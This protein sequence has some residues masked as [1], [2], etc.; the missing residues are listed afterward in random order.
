MERIEYFV[1]VSGAVL[2][3]SVAAYLL[4]RS[5]R[6]LEIAD[7]IR[8]VILPDG[9]GGPP[10]TGAS[11]MTIMVGFGVGMVTLFASL[12]LCVLGL[13]SVLPAWTVV[14]LPGPLRWA[15]LGLIWC[16]YGWGVAVVA[17]NLNYTPCNRRVTGT[18]RVATGGPYAIVRH[19][20]Y[21]AKAVFPVLLFMATG[22]W[23]ALL[24][25]IS[26]IALGFQAKAEEE[27]LLGLVGEPY[28]RY[29]EKTGRFIPRRR[30][31]R[32]LQPPP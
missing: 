30:P 22:R 3:S 12:V 28:Q 10:G 14:A 29:L 5:G 31:V 32:P 23:I 24:G 8:V 1:G 26:W 18:Y 7:G 6:R 15:A 25:M 13:W 20:M 27:Q 11:R 2:V 17:C 4:R 19:P 21:V 16:Y 9:V